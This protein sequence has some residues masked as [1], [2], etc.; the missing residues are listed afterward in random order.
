MAL[1]AYKMRRLGGKVEVYHLAH[2]WVEALS[3]KPDTVKI[4]RYDAQD[5]GF[6]TH[7]ESHEN[8]KLT[9]GA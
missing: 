1:M 2:G 8:F 5:G 3:I 6:V 4:K 9:G 7:N